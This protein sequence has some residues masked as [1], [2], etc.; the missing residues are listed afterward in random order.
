M[1]EE[2]IECL[3]V[4]ISELQGQLVSLR[5]AS[6]QQS[7]EENSL[8]ICMD[9]K[10]SLIEC[11][12][13][14]HER[15]LQARLK[16]AEEN[17]SREKEELI[18]SKSWLEERIRTLAQASQEEKMELENGFHE[19]LQRL[20]EKQALEMDQLQQELLRVHQ[21]ELQEQK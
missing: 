17:F 13:I 8:Q 2:Q 6:S 20:M 4:Q 1:L 12:R 16:E 9:E 7:V 19:K 15:E 21:Q 3:Q 14:D 10:A 5:Q 11:L 18:Q